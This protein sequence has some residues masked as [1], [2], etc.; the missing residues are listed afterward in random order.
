MEVLYYYSSRNTIVLGD[1]DQVLMVR[2]V[3]VDDLLRA[4]TPEVQHIVDK[5]VH[6]FILGDIQEL[7]FRHCGMEI[8]QDAE[9]CDIRVTRR[10]NEEVETSLKTRNPQVNRI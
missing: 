4:N 10:E 5:I 3:D 1:R 8:Q 2:T 7:S 9:T 6:A